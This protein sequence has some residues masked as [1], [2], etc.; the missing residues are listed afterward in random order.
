MTCASESSARG[1]RAAHRDSDLRS[2]QQHASDRRTRGTAVNCR[3]IVRAVISD[4]PDAA[5]LA[6]AAAMGIPADVALA[7]RVSGSRQPTTARSRNLV[8]AY[9]PELV[10][11]AG[12]MR[13]LTPHFID[14]VRRPHPQYPSFAAAEISRPAYAPAGPRSGRCAHGV[15]VHFVT[16]ELDGGPVIIQA[17]VPV[18]PAGHRESLSARV[19]RQE[20]RIYPQA[21]EWFAR[22]RLQLADERVW[23]DGQPLREP[24]RDR[25][26]RRMNCARFVMSRSSVSGAVWVCRTDHAGNAARRAT[27]AQ[28]F[29][30]HLC[31]DL[32]RHRMAARCG[33]NWR[34]DAQTRSLRV[35]DAC[36]PIDACAAVR[37][38]DAFERT[39]ARSRPPMACGRCVGNR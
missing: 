30:C 16:Q 10:V 19:Q 35:R 14:A 9:A 20:H 36:E 27:V 17:C 23:L 8:A 34:R 29:R 12:F 39:D 37:Q 5:G 1:A 22:G 13:I 26:A 2:R 24:R 33:W 21:I 38:R 18:L 3:S 7:A 31:G 25:R 4:R 6:I 28:T 11:L 15:S 32:P